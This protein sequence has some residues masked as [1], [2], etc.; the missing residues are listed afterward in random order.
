MRG[1]GVFRAHEREWSTARSSGGASRKRLSHFFTK[2]RERPRQVANCSCVQSGCCR[3]RHRRAARSA[4][5][6]ASI[7]SSIVVQANEFS[8]LEYTSAWSAMKMGSRL[9]ACWVT[10][11][12]KQ[13]SHEVRKSY[14]LGEDAVAVSVDHG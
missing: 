7:S 5:H 1:G 6:C 11:R 4:I 9:P 10:V 14:T 8:A 3:A 13:R 12:S 2:L